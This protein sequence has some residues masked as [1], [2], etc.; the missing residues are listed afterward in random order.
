MI[1]GGEKRNC[2]LAFE[3][4]NSHVCE[5]RS[6]MAD[7]TN[8]CLRFW[9]LGLGSSFSAHPKYFFITVIIV[10]KLAPKLHDGEKPYKNSKHSAYHS[11]RTHRSYSSL[12]FSGFGNRKNW[13]VCDSE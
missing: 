3:L 2:Q 13:Q 6:N 7:N 4:Q 10:N 12:F 1:D 5:K 11:K 9:V 8:S